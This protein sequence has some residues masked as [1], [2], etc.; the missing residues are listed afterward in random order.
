MRQISECLLQLEVSPSVSSFHLPGASAFTIPFFLA[1][2]LHEAALP[3]T[4]K[5]MAE[6]SVAL[7]FHG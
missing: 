6:S 5:L 1:L 2:Q 3:G 4:L 7:K